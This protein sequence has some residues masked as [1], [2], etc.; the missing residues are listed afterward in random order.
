M[1]IF[2]YVKR[3]KVEEEVRN[4]LLPQLVKEAEEKA[5]KFLNGESRNRAN[6]SFSITTKYDSTVDINKL[7]RVVNAKVT[8]FKHLR[9]TLRIQDSME[10]RRAEYDESIRVVKKFVD[11][12]LSGCIED[13]L[14]LDEENLDFIR[15][16]DS[17]RLDDNE[18]SS[19]VYR[20]F[21]TENPRKYRTINSLTYLYNCYIRM[22]K[23]GPK[24]RVYWGVEV[25]PKIIA[26]DKELSELIPKKVIEQEF[27]EEL[28]NSLDGHIMY[29]TTTSAKFMLLDIILTTTFR[30]ENIQIA[31]LAID[32]NMDKIAYGKK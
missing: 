29:T 11:K 26:N 5:L 23:D 19:I 3:S 16:F 9:D 4:E 20:E 7:A 6:M 15:D 14:K 32:G 13:I 8:D 24:V 2:G 1:S 28:L 21:I 25:Q 17:L 12:H 10:S 18:K 27:T 31:S 30:G 22:E